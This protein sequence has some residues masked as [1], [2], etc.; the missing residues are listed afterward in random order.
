[1]LQLALRRTGDPEVAEL[2]G[3]VA[4]DLEAGLADLR[5]LAHGIHP[6]VLTDRGLPAALDSLAARSA[7]PVIV[8]SALDRRIDPAVETALY[9]TAAEALTNVAKYADATEATI[10]LTVDGEQVAIAIRDDGRGGASLDAGSGLRGLVDRLGAL[11]G[12]LNVESPT[13]RGTTVRAVVPLAADAQA[14]AGS[15]R[16]GV[17]ASSALRA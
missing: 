14:G 11:G 13:G 7:V 2:L 4:G 17:A 12:R 8:D 16:P 10:H 15:G 5:E 9:F 6:A 3:R 1:M